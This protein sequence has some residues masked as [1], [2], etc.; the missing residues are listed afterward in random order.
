MS[1]EKSRKERLKL[2]NIVTQRAMSEPCPYCGDLD[3][4]Y[5]GWAQ[6]SQLLKVDVSEQHF[7]EPGEIRDRDYHPEL[8]PDERDK[9]RALVC[10]NCGF[11][12]LFRVPPF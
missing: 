12:K 10:M 9:Y 1:E 6:R 11:T 5:H 2:V 4:G 3:I 8:L 7:G